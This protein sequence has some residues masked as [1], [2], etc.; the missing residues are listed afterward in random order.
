MPL[1][2]IRKRNGDLAEFDR[3]R[4]EQAIEAA[5][6]AVGEPDRAFISV[7]TDFIVKDIEHV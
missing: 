4:I 6:I 2:K 1:L 3:A 5:C 7:V